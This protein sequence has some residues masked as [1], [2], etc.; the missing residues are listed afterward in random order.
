MV[1]TQ[2]T[3]NDEA[4]DDPNGASIFVGGGDDDLQRRLELHAT[5]NESVMGVWKCLLPTLKQTF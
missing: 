2:Q 1:G 5:S 4:E 3:V